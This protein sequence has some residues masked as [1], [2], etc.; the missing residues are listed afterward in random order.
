MI[1]ERVLSVEMGGEEK[2][3]RAAIEWQLISPPPPSTRTYF[4]TIVSEHWAHGMCGPQWS[5]I[6]RIVH[7]YKKPKVS[8][9]LLWEIV[10]N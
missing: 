5:K 1:F 6:K 4:T 8:D 3:V 10:K 2:C 7:L 9:K